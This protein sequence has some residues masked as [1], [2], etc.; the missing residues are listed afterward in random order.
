MCRPD[1][2]HH[3]LAQSAWW[4]A[5]MWKLRRSRNAREQWLVRAVLDGTTLYFGR[6]CC[7]WSNGREEPISFERRMGL[8]IEA[9]LD[10]EFVWDVRRAFRPSCVA[11]EPSDWTLM[12]CIRGRSLWRFR[13]SR[14]GYGGCRC[15]G[16]ISPWMGMSDNQIWEHHSFGLSCHASSERGQSNCAGYDEALCLLDRCSGRCLRPM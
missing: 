3:G 15:W 13:I 4:M 16:S 9:F 5:A 1:N 11:P 2:V 14:D 8:V 7:D 6:R 10:P 12:R